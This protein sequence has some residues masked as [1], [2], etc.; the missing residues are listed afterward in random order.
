MELAAA[1]AANGTTHPQAAAP[2]DPPVG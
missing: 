1:R 2:S